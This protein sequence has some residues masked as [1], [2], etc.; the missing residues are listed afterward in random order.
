MRQTLIVDL[1]GQREDRAA[2]EHVER[3]PNRAVGLWFWIAHRGR[4]EDI[5]E[6]VRPWP[7]PRPPRRAQV[8]A[9][10]PGRRAACGPGQRL[11]QPLYLRP[12][13]TDAALLGADVAEARRDVVAHKAAHQ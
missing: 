12:R 3:Q 11:R 4:V 9:R 5:D 6:V 1:R 8:V 7:R 13:L 2:A 10:L